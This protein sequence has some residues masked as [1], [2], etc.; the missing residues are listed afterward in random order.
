MRKN[1]KFRTGALISLMPELTTPILS[2]RQGVLRRELFMISNFSLWILESIIYNPILKGL[3][4]LNQM[5]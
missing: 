3:A 5:S 2:L 4:M 1:I